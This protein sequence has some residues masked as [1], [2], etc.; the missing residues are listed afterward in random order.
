VS[1]HHTIERMTAKDFANALAQI[2]MTKVRAAELLGVT[3]QQIHNW[4]KGKTK[5][6]RAVQIVVQAWVAVKAK[7]QAV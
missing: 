1:E 6:P 3:R 4:A 5:V 2:N 7:D